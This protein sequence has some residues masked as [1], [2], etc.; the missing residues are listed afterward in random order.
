MLTLIVP[1]LIWPQQAL[2]DLTRD[3]ALP[4][5][6][7]LL[8]YGQL[9]PDGPHDAHAALAATVG[10]SAPLPAAALR[11]LASRRTPDESCWLA[12][13]PVH[14][15]LEQTRVR[16][17]DPQ[18]LALDETE[19]EQLAVSLAPALC[20]PSGTFRALGELVRLTPS[21]WN[22][23]LDPDVPPPVQT[24]PLPQAIGRAVTPLPA[25]PANRVWLAALNEAQMVLHEHP[26]NRAREAAGRPV[27][28]SLWPWGGG[29]LGA[30]R[31]TEG[32]PW[33][34]GQAR[35]DGALVMPHGVPYRHLL[36][37]DALA[38]G[39]GR[40]LELDTRPLGERTLAPATLVFYAA[41]ALPAQLG[42]ATR[43]RDA[44]L[45]LERDW[46]AP[47]LAILRE[48]HIEAIHLLLPGEPQGRQLLLRR[49]DLLRFWRS[50][51]PL[52][53]LASP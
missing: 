51:A 12:L 3:L 37:D 17:G 21:L 5:F 42:E 48:G 50:P 14:L 53:R 13:D 6:G 4:A 8:R 52:T 46:L 31:S 15:H 23:R 32:H 27:V 22:L 11:G 33:I 7:A 19:A 38:S 26:V 18:Q 20:V 1:G 16:L 36:A 9:T 28:N 49:R 41:L 2:A 40:W 45:A 43:W 34:P 29:R 39:L 47:A 44:L 24:T 25:A 30:S 10:L 35:N